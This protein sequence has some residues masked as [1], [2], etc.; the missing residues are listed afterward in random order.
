M[1]EDVLKGIYIPPQPKLIDEIKL[2]K[3]DLDEIATRISADPGVS[4]AV[5]KTVNS[6]FFGLKSP[7]VSISQAVILL[8]IDRVMN[9]VKSMLLKSSMAKISTSIN[10]ERFWE[11]SS[12]V[13]IVSSAICRQ[14]NLG[15][16]DEAYTLGLFHNAG[17]PII[18]QQVSNYGQIIQD[19]YAREDGKITR[20][21]FKTIGMHHAAAGYRLTRVWKL[22]KLIAEA[23]K[24]HHSVERL[25]DD[26]SIENP[27]LK[28]LVSVLKISEHMVKLHSRLGNCEV[29][30]EWEQNKLSVL[31][32]LG[33]SE[34][35]EEDLEDAVSYT[36]GGIP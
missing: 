26:N 21:E 35:D 17:V 3:T 18:A 9:I 5:L 8:G 27:K 25:L 14:L 20:E 10:M 36:L 30:Y 33:L 7:I 19:S 2:A 28:S 29:D 6:P 22:P 16:T 12:A 15:L 23:V 32:F 24:N 11:S 31:G 13:A 4:A 1:T 34:Y